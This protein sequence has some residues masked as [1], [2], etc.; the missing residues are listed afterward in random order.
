MLE[1]V[2]DGVTGYIVP[3]DDILGLARR[4]E[5]LLRDDALR[6]D[7]GRAAWERAE[8]EL[9]PAAAVSRLVALW[10]G[11]ARRAAHASLA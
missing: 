10:S 4:L 3:I 8:A 5:V 6:S 9:S 11:A 7:F 2:E 1:L